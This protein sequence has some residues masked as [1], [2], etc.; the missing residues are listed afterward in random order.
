MLTQWREIK[1][2]PG[3]WTRFD[4]RL[5]LATMG[6]LLLLVAILA[7]LPA[8]AAALLFVLLLILW[9]KVPLSALAQR[10]PGVA[11]IL[12]LLLVLP[13]TA[14]GPGWGPTSARGWYWAAL[15]ALKILAAMG[16]SAV[17]A[18]TTTLPQA[19]A[20][21]EAFGLPARG[22]H[23]LMLLARYL[24]LLGRQVAQYRLA[25]RLRGFRNRPNLASYR[26]LGRVAGSLLVRGHDRAERVAQALAVR[27][28][29][30]RSRLLVP[31]CLCRADVLMAGVL[32][33]GV[34]CLCILEWLFRSS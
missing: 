34:A 11:A 29:T 25:L 16:C 2:E 24:H 10:L 9:A 20:A 6:T 33:F 30:G 17:L 23:L 1:S 21:G 32:A 27:G 19:L 5:K 15:L 7:S 12:A 28:Y 14:P 26:T 18:A 8:A 31:F 4:A 3:R 13:F 22:T